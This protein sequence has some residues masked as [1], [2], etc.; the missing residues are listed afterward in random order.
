MP[1]GAVRG[2]GESLASTRR[3]F[4]EVRSDDPVVTPSADLG[5]EPVFDVDGVRPPATGPVTE[6]R[7]SLWADLEG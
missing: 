1:L 2:D 3:D 7:W 5:T 4:V 6:P